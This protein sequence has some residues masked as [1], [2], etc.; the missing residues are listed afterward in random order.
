[1]TNKK[2][3]ER[4]YNVFKRTISL[5]L[6]ILI[7]VGGVPLTR[8]EEV[9]AASSPG[10]QYFAAKSDWQTLN[11]TD[12]SKSIKINLGTVP[13][14]I[15]NA[16]Y[17]PTDSSIGLTTGDPITWWVVG[18]NGSE[19]N[20][21]S[22][23]TLFRAYYDKV[24]HNAHSGTDRYTK[25]GLSGSWGENGYGTY[26]DGSKPN[27]V[28]INHYG[29]SD[30]RNNILKSL[31][32]ALF[33]TEENKIVTNSEINCWDNKNGKTYTV[34][35]KLYLPSG[36]AETANMDY[37]SSYTTIYVPDSNGGFNNAIPLGKWALN[38][39][40][41]WLRSPYSFDYITALVTWPV[42]TSVASL[43]A[44]TLTARR[45]LLKLIFHL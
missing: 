3:L 14:N 10:L 20:L 7:G 17:Q 34:T 8:L 2:I 33:K 37:G 29:A 42:M 21:Y 35:D 13:S 23:K 43:S 45:P 6:A 36:G 40:V 22:E 39:A 41:D 18:A 30:I 24:W 15:A 27:E 38:Y 28:Y 9:H 19:A 26:K 1:M 16:D 44:S 5:I 31:H 11:L 4:E 12:D 25:T 32:N